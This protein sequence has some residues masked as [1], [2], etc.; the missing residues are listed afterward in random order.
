ME[1]WDQVDNNLPRR[2]LGAYQVGYQILDAAGTPLAGYEQPR[3]NIVFNRMPREDSATVVAY[4]PDSGITVHGSAVTRFRYLVTNTVRDGLVET[5][6][7]QPEALPAGD[8]II[9]GSARD[10]SGNEAIGE[11]E[12][13]VTLLP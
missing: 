8:Y 13:K 3:F 7:W 5:G 4:A 12:L 6:R 1:A 10:Y 11:R 9:R 2:R